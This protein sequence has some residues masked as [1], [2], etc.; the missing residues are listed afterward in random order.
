MEPKL[1]NRLG[2]IC[3]AL[4]SLSNETTPK[5]LREKLWDK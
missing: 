5:I 2:A 3:R 1:E 4:F